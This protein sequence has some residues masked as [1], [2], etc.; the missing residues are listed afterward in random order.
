[1]RLLRSKSLN[2]EAVELDKDNECLQYNQLFYDSLHLPNHFKFI[3]D[4][5]KR[6]ETIEASKSE[7]E[8]I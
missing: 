1:L 3:V 7:I 6:F 2:C 5:P 4:I 8:S